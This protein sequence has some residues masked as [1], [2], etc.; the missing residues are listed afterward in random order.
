[1]PRP[2]RRM[3]ALPSAQEL[4]QGESPI[5]L[6][7]KKDR[8]LFMTY[9]LLA[10]ALVRR[11]MFPH[12]S[13]KALRWKFRRQNLLQ[14]FLEFGPDL[15]CLQE[16]DFWDEFY[17]PAL[18]KSGY[19]SVFYKNQNKKHGCAIV[20]RKSR[21]EKVD[22]ATIEYDD[23]GQPTFLTGNIGLMVGLRPVQHS[24][25]NPDPNADMLLP[26]EDEEKEGQKDV[27]ASVN[28]FC[29]QREV[30][31]TP[32]GIL[33]ATTHLFWRP[34]G[35]YERLRQASIFLKK[36]KEWNEDLKY[37]V[38]LGGDFNTTPRDAAYRAMTRN[39]MPPQQIPD[40][41]TWLTNEVAR[42]EEA[43]AAKTTSKGTDGELKV[44]SDEIDQLTAKAEN[45]DLEGS[46]NDPS[47]KNDTKIEKETSD[48]PY[49]A[50]HRGIL[51]PKQK[52]AT[53]SVVTDQSSSTI[54]NAADFASS[55]DPKIKKLAEKD[56]T[57][58]ANNESGE[59]ARVIAPIEAFTPPQ[60]LKAAIEA[61]PR[62]I[63]IYGQYEILI[64]DNPA[65]V[66]AGAAAK[67]D[68]GNT[69]ATK[70]HTH[71]THGEPIFTNFAT[72]FK[73]TLDYVY[74]LDEP[75]PEN[76]AR[77][78]PLKFLEVPDQSFLGHGLPDENFSSDHFCL[79][80]EFALLCK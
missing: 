73:D 33:V 42:E 29:P 70:A 17:L 80:V 78:V 14:E 3:I 22:Q 67:T 39:E 52:G 76:G 38:L 72:W 11:D 65:Q 40:L 34:D 9:N 46:G 57:S 79:M 6:R 2:H 15:A 43:A 50:P 61:S 58:A 30:A 1:M 77:L 12:A 60:E 64:K 71:H 59:D 75:L 41:Q 51:L 48:L 19:E 20:W 47:S 16:V 7:K 21:F 55:Q 74:L 5:R 8:F 35:S 68:T 25:E 23:V 4:I 53:A 66:S 63:S 37:T 31:G 13:Q 62:C 56:A 28:A 26:D 45:L 24:A 10:Q 44:N 18:T 27:T 49:R 69:T 54:A 36:I 32:G